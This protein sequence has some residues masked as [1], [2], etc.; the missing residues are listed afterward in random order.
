M[1]M[2]L[3]ASSRAESQKGRGEFGFD[4]G[5]EG[6][7]QPDLFLGRILL[8]AQPELLGRSPRVLADIA[9]EKPVLAP[10]QLLVVH[11][12]PKPESGI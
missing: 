3:A 6:S 1:A 12:T 7:D 11:G 9:G 8:V 10:L 5:P 2:A 4:F